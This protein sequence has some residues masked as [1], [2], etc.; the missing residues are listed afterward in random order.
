MQAGWKRRW[1]NCLE[2]ILLHCCVLYRYQ[3]DST[4]T[5]LWR[6]LQS[7]TFHTHSTP[8][9]YDFS[10]LYR[11]YS[12]K[13]SASLSSKWD[14]AKPS[15]LRSVLLC[16]MAPFSV[17]LVATIFPKSLVVLVV[18]S[19]D[20]RKFLRSRCFVFQCLPGKNPPKGAQ[21]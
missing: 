10:I 20:G 9:I 15:E 8:F 2:V 13:F 21:G 11:A 7:Q 16:P 3:S 1:E 5:T 17:F 4:P 18:C 19:I 6:I 12:E 14:S